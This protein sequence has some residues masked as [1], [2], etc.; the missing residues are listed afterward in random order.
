MAALKLG[1][2]TDSHE[3]YLSTYAVLSRDQNPY[4]LGHIGDISFIVPTLKTNHNSLNAAFL[5]WNLLIVCL[6]YPI[7]NLLK[8]ASKTSLVIVHLRLIRDYLGL[9]ARKP[10]FEG[11]RTTKAQTS[12]GLRAD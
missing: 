4:E 6:S 11:L 5:I 2:S 12:L 3:S 1:K 7:N 10:V 8:K 9:Y